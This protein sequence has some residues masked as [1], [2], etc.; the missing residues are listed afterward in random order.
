LL[1]FAREL[2]SKKEK[3]SQEYPPRLMALLD[4]GVQCV[5][6][7]ETEPDGFSMV[8]IKA[9]G[10]IDV[11][12]WDQDNENATKAEILAG[13]VARVWI[14]NSR[15]AFSCDGQPSYNLQSDYN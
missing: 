5:A 7:I 12:A 11:I 15:R 6:R 4:R 3:L 13:T 2:S 14:V 10:G 8:I 1:R 9:D